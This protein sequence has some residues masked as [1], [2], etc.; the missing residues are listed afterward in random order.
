MVGS[1]LWK[2][3]I[4]S[5]GWQNMA[6]YQTDSEI[7]P[8]V[9]RGGQN[10]QLLISPTADHNRL[11][12]L[13]LTARAAELNSAVICSP[14]SP[15][16]CVCTSL[17]GSFIEGMYDNYRH[18]AHLPLEFTANHSSIWAA[19][20]FLPSVILGNVSSL[21]NISP[22]K[23][24]KQYSF[25]SYHNNTCAHAVDGNFHVTFS[26]ISDNILRLWLFFLMVSWGCV[27]EMPTD[28]GR[29][30]SEQFGTFHS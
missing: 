9:S 15:L 2:R 14:S 25:L 26:R 28:D 4:F 13:M 27:G 3:V 7:T 30:H 6:I 19:V 23:T 20:M 12:C 21:P 11:Q 18:L 16:A 5:P 24:Q 22:L 17:W 1:S 29:G 10:V 8:A